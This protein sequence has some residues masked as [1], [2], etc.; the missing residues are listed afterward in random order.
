M[1]NRNLLASVV[2]P[3]DFSEGSQLA[4]ERALQLPLGPKAKVTLLHVV[5]DDIP[6]VLRKEAL[7]EGERSLE[8]QLAR[9]HGL[10][11]ARGL[12]PRQFVLD[13]V[14]GD[15]AAQIL[16]RARTVEA[17]VVCMGRHGRT[18]SLLDL[19]LGST[20]KKVVRQGD[21]PVLLARVAA[22]G[23]YQ[24]ALVAVD[25]TL[26]SPKVVRAARAYVGEA[27]EVELLHASSV[28]FEDYV[29]LSGEK[30]EQFREEAYRAAAKDLEAL[31]AKTGLEAS[32]RVV[33]GD[34]RLLLLEEA[35]ARR[36]ELIVVGTH[37]RKGLRKLLLGSVAEWVLTHAACDVLVTRG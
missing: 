25:L 30:A 37:G 4:L 14:E 17:D 27:A 31:L 33:G 24:R 29:V 28:P 32:A 13:V 26:A 23:P 22:R 11:A 6:G 20:A 3:T 16:K 7:A 8:K 10:A 1:P 2:V 18:T 36:A 5:P 15:G 21:V 34:A 9:V 35:K 19:H 12:S